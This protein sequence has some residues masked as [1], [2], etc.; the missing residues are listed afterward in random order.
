MVKPLRRRKKLRRTDPRFRRRGD[1]S[2]TSAAPDG[3]GTDDSS[4]LCS[5]SEPSLDSGE[6]YGS[7][8]KEDFRKAGFT[9]FDVP[10]E[11]TGRRDSEGKT[12]AAESESEGNSCERGR[13]SGGAWIYRAALVSGAAFGAVSMGLLMGR[14]SGCF[15]HVEYLGAL[16]PT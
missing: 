6:D 15:Y 5:C 1:Y 4:S 3:G 10:D 13:A 14:F 11:L 7:P 12:A 2:V 16:T 8:G 9:V